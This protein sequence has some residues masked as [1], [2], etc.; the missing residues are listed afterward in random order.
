[1]RYVPLSA[2]AIAALVALAGCAA[3]PLDEA[4]LASC[5]QAL[6][7]GPL[8]TLADAGLTGPACA[9]EWLY[10]PYRIERR[11]DAAAAVARAPA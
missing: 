1:M 9:G 8:C 5:E 2:A 11:A 10:T 3:E 4:E 6:E 7:T